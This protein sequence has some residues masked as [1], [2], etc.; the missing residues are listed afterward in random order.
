MKRLAGIIVAFIAL[1]ACFAAVGCGQS[2]GS[3]ESAITVSASASTDM[4]PDSASFS[5]VAIGDGATE[6]EAQKAAE[7][8]AQAIIAKLKEI[9]GSNMQFTT[10]YS[11]ATMTYTQSGVTAQEPTGYLDWNGNWVDTG[12]QEVYYDFGEVP[13]YEITATIALESIKLDQMN[14]MMRTAAAAGAKS[15]AEVSFSVLDREAAYQT[16]LQAAV[17]AAHTKAEA[18]AKASNVYVGRVVNVT[19]DSSPDEL[20][21]TVAG[22]ASTYDVQNVAS[23]EID[24]PSVAIEAAVTVSYAIS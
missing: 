15:F 12:M 24:P 19:E 16:A 7:G 18:L 4:Q 23:L 14:N 1:S 9:A 11:E 8:S 17:D 2:S 3:P 6:E 10:K 20:E 22:D 5:I 13:A 21:L